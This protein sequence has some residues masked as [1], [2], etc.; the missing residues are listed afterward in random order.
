MS[1][2]CTKFDLESL[3]R[4]QLGKI[5]SK[6]N[7]SFFSSSPFSINTFGSVFHAG[8]SNFYTS[9]YNY[10]AEPQLFHKPDQF[11]IRFQKPSDFMEKV[12]R[13]IYKHKYIMYSPGSGYS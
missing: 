8:T 4:R 13:G 5:D 9:N 12:Q 7:M 2:Y 6:E 1:L 11:R 10:A 3:R